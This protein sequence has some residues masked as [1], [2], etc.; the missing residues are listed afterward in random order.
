MDAT[1]GLE[2][3]F[4]NSK[5]DSKRE[6][7]A[8]DFAKMFDGVILDGVFPT[9][10]DCFRIR[11]LGDGMKI[12]VGSGKAWLKHTYSYLPDAITFELDAGD[13]QSPRID[14]VVLR[15]GCSELIRQNWIYVKTGTPSSNPQP[16]AL[17]GDPDVEGL[18]VYEYPLGYIKVKALAESLDPATDMIV[19]LAGAD[20]DPNGYFGDKYLAKSTDVISKADI[21]ALE[22]DVEN[23]NWTI[24][25]EDPD[26][27]GVYYTK[28]IYIGNKIALDAKIFLDMK[29]PTPS[30][31][32]PINKIQQMEEAFGNM[33]KHEITPDKQLLIY[34][35]SVPQVGYR[36]RV[37]GKG[38][39]S[40]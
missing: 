35:Y 29:A 18:N 32:N 1:E 9:I 5:A 16:P 39:S 6:Y 19:S 17:E 26:N 10:G 8:K 34:S 20:S 24:H 22:F 38:V 4:Y 33:F 31:E 7:S 3:G 37:T 2:Y 23:T 28:A 13:A 36:I 40:E 25:N 15:I 21:G 11:A 27:I 30:L 14:L 12:E